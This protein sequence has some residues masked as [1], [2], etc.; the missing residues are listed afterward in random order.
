MD[1]KKEKIEKT[2]QSSR[3]A[4]YNIELWIINEKGNV[5]N[6]LI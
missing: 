3:D 6:K 1:D 5:I 4:G 2:L